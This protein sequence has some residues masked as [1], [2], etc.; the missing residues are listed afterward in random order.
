MSMLDIDY[1]SGIGLMSDEPEATAHSRH[2]RKHPDAASGTH[3]LRAL[4][5]LDAVLDQ[6]VELDLRAFEREAQ[7]VARIASY[8]GPT[9]FMQLA[10]FVLRDREEHEFHRAALVPALLA[11]AN[12]AARRHDL[13]YV[14]ER[15]LRSS[16][17][18][19]AFVDAADPAD[20]PTLFTRL[21]RL[22]RPELAV[23]AAAAREAVDEM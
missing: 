16:V 8:L 10:A 22:D 23:V 20:W 14:M 9:G 5:V 2:P 21:A 1:D 17:V 4:D 7:K 6:V 18:G 12:T 15:N 11:S 19:M 3:A 13:V